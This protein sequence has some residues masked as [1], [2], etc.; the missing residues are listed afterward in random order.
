[1]NCHDF[2]EFHLSGFGFQ[3]A[4]DLILCEEEPERR[5][6]AESCNLCIV[7]VGATPRVCCPNNTRSWASISCNFDC[8]RKSSYYSLG[9]VAKAWSSL[10]NF[11]VRYYMWSPRSSWT[12][13]LVDLSQRSLCYSVFDSL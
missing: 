8:G 5:G 9:S 2:C 6:A 11:E 3:C 12:S 4:G 13:G 10:G 7:G 1:M